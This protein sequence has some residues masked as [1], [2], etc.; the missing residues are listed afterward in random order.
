[1]SRTGA[2]HKSGERTLTDQDYEGIKS[3]IEKVVSA[4]GELHEG[5]RALKKAFDKCCIHRGGDDGGE[6]KHMR[7]VRKR[8]S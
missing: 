3:A 1:M 5:V 2:A 8:A 4:S 6:Q 7:V